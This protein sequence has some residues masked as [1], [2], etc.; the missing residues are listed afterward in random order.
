MDEDFSKILSEKKRAY[1]IT[2]AGCGK[3]E[4]IAR[5]IGYSKDAAKKQLIL[6]HTHAGVK[7]LHD[8]LKKLRIPRKFYH[9]DTIAGLALQY[10][11][12]F[13]TSSGLG[14]GYDPTSQEWDK[15]YLAAKLI[16]SS[17]VGKK[18]IESSY[19]GLYVDEYQDCTI[20][21]HELIL[22]LAE[23]LPCRILG[24]PLQG[25]FG[26]G[27]NRIVNWYENIFPQFE[28]VGSRT[29]VR[30][31]YRWKGKNEDLGDWLLAIR[32]D[33]M[34]GRPIDFRNLP[35]G[36][37]WIQLDPRNQVITQRNVCLGK[38]IS[39][40]TVV[41][42]Q[43]WANQAHSLAKMLN[44]AYTSMEEVD[45]RDLN[46]WASDLETATGNAKA[47]AA[48]DFAS[49]CMTEVSTAL[50]TIRRKLE[51]GET[52][53]NKSL[54]YRDIFEDL[55]TLSTTNDLSLLLRVFS[56]TEQIQGRII[57][58]KELWQDMKSAIEEKLK[59]KETFSLQK[60]A[61]LL[62]DKNRTWGRMIDRR[63]VSRTLLVKGLEFDH[64]IVLNADNLG[65]KELYVALTRGAK[66]LTV[67][68]SSPI[69]QKEPPLDLRPPQ[70]EAA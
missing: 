59:S 69:I 7:S 6:T 26:F 14:I 44:G 40:E 67:L 53:A 8:R 45:S 63:T 4:I 41:A 17:H 13:P 9:I 5:A 52:T 12:S 58:R 10:A 39:G 27:D 68:S 42:I 20:Q 3:T 30:V 16:I 37:Q 61:W 48:I 21:Q 19:S 54:Q 70:P 65:A 55:V 11:A 57:Y 47:I 29:T 56:K 18:I 33:L 36:C 34:A 66:S 43:Q 46:K 51:R 22:Q 50:S 24:D 2:P 38:V 64:A 60:T 49:L 31:P 32:D 35:R 1:L 25:I 23:I 28:Q 62:R 15:V